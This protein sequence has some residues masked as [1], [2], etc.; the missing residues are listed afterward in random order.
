[1]TVTAHRFEATRQIEHIPDE[2]TGH[3]GLPVNWSEYRVYQC[4][5]C[6]T[7]AFGNVFL[8]YDENGVMSIDTY[9]PDPGVYPN[10]EIGPECDPAEVTIWETMGS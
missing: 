4:S 1:M 8:W 6:G 9:D 5:R 7:A 2:E 10:Q 3:D